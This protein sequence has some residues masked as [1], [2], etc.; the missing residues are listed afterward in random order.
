MGLK[1]A[2]MG[3]GNAPHPP[4]KLQENSEKMCPAAVGVN[5]VY[6]DFPGKPG[7]PSQFVGGISVEI[8]EYYIDGTAGRLAAYP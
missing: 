3:S 2:G 7:N 1:M 6:A 8:G 5:H 4:K